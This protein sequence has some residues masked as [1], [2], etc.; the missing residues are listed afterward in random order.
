M[1]KEPCNIC[2]E[3]LNNSTRKA[4]T[5]N[6][7]NITICKQC[8]ERYLLETTQDPHCMSCRKMWNREFLQTN[9]TQKFI[10]KDLKIHRQ[11]VLYQREM[12]M[13]PETQ[14][15]VEREIKKEKLQDEYVNL[16]NLIDN[17]RLQQIELSNR[18]R[19]LA[20]GEDDNDITSLSEKRHNV[21]VKACPVDNCKGFLSTQWK[22]GIC[23][24]WVCPDCHEIKGNKK[25]VPHTCNAEC[26]ET[27]K[28]LSKDSKPCPKCGSMCTKVDGC[29]QVFA[30]CCQTTFDWKTGKIETGAIHAPDYYRWL[31]RTGQEIQREHLDIPCGGIPHIND[32][33]RAFHIKKSID[34]VSNEENINMYNTL[35]T[36]YRLFIHIDRVMIPPYHNVINER[37]VVD[38]RDLR[39]KYMRNFIDENKLKILV[40]QREK[41]RAKKQEIYATLHTSVL[42]FSDIMQQALEKSRKKINTEYQIENA[43]QTFN[44]LLELKNFTN[45]SMKN[46]SLR[47]NCNTPHIDNNWKLLSLNEKKFITKSASED[48]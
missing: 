6:Y 3:T 47:Y 20:M 10:D 17:M 28:L 38:N 35:L 26:L 43:K 5:C 4:V 24:T 16:T 29:N 41:A 22:C 40:Q 32:V 8:T 18:I 2:Y 1:P 33:Q 27:A 19:R 12:S 30:I 31:Q 23:E 37:N 13:L 36:I 14:V 11:N 42:A 9:F 46:I 45:E 44:E 25:D 15:Y 7:C 48:T 39:I 21:F 34:N